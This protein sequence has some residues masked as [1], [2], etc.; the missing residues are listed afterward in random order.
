M[1]DTVALLGYQ[2]PSGGLILESRQ[3]AEEVAMPLSEYEQRVLD[4]LERDLG[5]DPRLK[6]A[7]TRSRGTVGRLVVAVV[8][9][10]VGLGVV[11]AGVMTK[12]WLIGIGGFA[13]MITIVLWA[14]LG[15]SASGRGTKRPAKGSAKSHQGFMTRLEE[16]FE[17]RREQ[18]G[19]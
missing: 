18:G 6:S 10:V 11:L 13:L 17:R 15:P 16:R 19:V 3:A 2:T 7:M 4:D 8:G 9:V 12:V 1:S 5:S 14:L